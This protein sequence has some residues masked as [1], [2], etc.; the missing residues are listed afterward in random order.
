[1]LSH[2]VGVVWK[3]THAVLHLQVWSSTYMMPLL[4]LCP[5]YGECESHSQKP[6]LYLKMHFYSHQHLLPSEYLL[7]AKLENLDFLTSNQESFW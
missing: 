5:T 4:M 2:F 7:G 3:F 1:M 6:V